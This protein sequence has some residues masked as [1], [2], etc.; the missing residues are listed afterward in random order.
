[1]SIKQLTMRD[2]FF[3]KLYDLAKQDR[4]IVIVSAD[5]G[6]PSLD[7]FRR[8]LSAQ[9]VNVGIAEQNMLNIAVG[10]AMSGKKV[11]C[12]AI[13]PFTALRPYEFI[14][15]NVSCMNVPVNL[16][17]VGAGYS[18][19]DSGPTHHST[20][21]ISIM[22]V[23]PN[24]EVLNPSDANMAAAFAEH[25]TKRLNPT[26]IRLDRITQPDK[27]KETEKFK[28]GFSELIKGDKICIVGTGN[29]VTNAMEVSKKLKNKKIGVIDFYRLKPV[30]T[31]EFVKTLSKYKHIISWEE[32]MLAGGMGSILSEIIT[33]NKL[34]IK[35]TRIGVNDRYHYYYGD[36]ENI[37]KKLNIDNQ[38]V[39]KTINKIS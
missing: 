32:H 26:Y 24:I 12:Y 30:K 17:G 18:Y 5:M 28:E 11:F 19:P 4:D 37:Q 20:E 8:D 2:A 35:L 16:I 33:D 3:N 14:K 39:I 10:L 27:Y 29:T 34:N 23:L 7:K 31:K 36:R 13:E 6:A 9:Y 1:M 25:G 21:D 15:V 38:T 22:R